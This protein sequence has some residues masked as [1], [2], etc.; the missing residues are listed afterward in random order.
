MKN[1]P[2]FLLFLTSSVHAQDQYNSATTQLNN[3]NSINKGISIGGYAEITYNNLEGSSTPAE[4]DVQR[5]VMLFAYKFDDRTS[6]VTEIEYE[7]VKEVYVEQA[8]INYSVADGINLRGGLMLIPMG[9]INEYHEPTTYNGVERPSLDS[10]IVPTTWREMGIGVSG[11]INNASIRY[12]AYLMNGFLSYGESHK[13]RGLDGLR[14]G[15]QKGAESVGTDVNFAG[16]IEYYGIPKLKLGVSYYTG[17]TQT[18]TP[19]ISN[20]QIG[21]SMFGLDY[22]YVNG[23][24][25]SRGQLISASLSDTEAY[26]LAGNT[27]LGSAMGGYYAEGAYN[28]LPLDSRQKLDIFLRYENFNTHQKTA[29]NLIANDAFHRNETTF[30]LSYHLANGAV[31]KA[32]YQSKGTAVEGSDA[33]GQFNLGLGVFF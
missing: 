24:L 12:Q 21:L 4:I 14:K 1:L 9:I 2:L 28:L 31:F 18:T 30:G 17:N 33:V 29:G 6:F 13:I 10:K 16:R 15:R 27:D 8:F 23:R 19:E 22:R 26:N 32:D 5:L 25:S 20:T 7:H 11:R 3:L